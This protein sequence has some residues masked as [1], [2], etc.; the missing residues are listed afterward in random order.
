MD[1]SL[2]TGQAIVEEKATGEQDDNI[3]GICSGQRQPA[4]LIHVPYPCPHAAIVDER[5]NSTVISSSGIEQKQY[6]SQ[7]AAATPSGVRGIRG[8]VG[9]YRGGGGG[10]GGGIGTTGGGDFFDPYSLSPYLSSS[11][12]SEEEASFRYCV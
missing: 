10:G 5:V 8:Y 11:S 3:N 1:P 7:E 2:A 12:S 9:S 6:N 4:M